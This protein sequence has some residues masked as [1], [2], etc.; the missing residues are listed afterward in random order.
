MGDLSPMTAALSPELLAQLFTQESNDPFLTLITLTHESFS[1][2]RL[3]NNSV[4]IVSRG[5]T[6]SAFP[7]KITLPVDDG[8]S[9][10]EVRMEFDNVGLEILD[11]IRSV[12]TPIGVKLEMVLAS[13]PDAVQI[14]LGELAIHQINYNKSR[15]SAVLIMD[16]FLNTEITSEKYVPSIYPGIF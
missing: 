13:I 1:T 9:A 7:V 16:G 8:E 14:E 11:E 3:V 2:I 4:D 5:E 10:R 15:I 6:F 12:T